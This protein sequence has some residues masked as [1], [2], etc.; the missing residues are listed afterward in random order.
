MANKTIGDLTLGSAISTSDLFETEQSGASRK[1]TGTQLR[2]F[3]QSSIPVATALQLGGVKAGEG[4]NIAGDG[5]LSVTGGGG[6]STALVAVLNSDSPG[7]TTTTPADVLTLTV[8]SGGVYMLDA[9]IIY[10]TT[11]VEKGIT[12]KFAGNAGVYSFGA[13]LT[14]VGNGETYVK[15]VSNFSSILSFPTSRTGADNNL[16]VANGLFYAA[17]SGTFILQYAS[18]VANDYCAIQKSSILQLNKV[19]HISV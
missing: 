9:R 15:S 13:N 8:E 10:R 12:F 17:S 1:V 2:T 3:I 5:T 18:P 16:M 6:G 7:N 4:V 11:A 19:G 14:V